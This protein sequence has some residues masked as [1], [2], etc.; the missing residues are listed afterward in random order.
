MVIDVFSS[1]VLKEGENT[2]KTWCVK[3]R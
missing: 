2:Q 1:N 3:F